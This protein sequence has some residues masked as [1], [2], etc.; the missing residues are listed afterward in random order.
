MKK[1]SKNEF[2]KINEISS[3]FL[4]IFSINFFIDKKPIFIDNIEENQE[5]K[6]VEN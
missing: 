6:K 1:Q 5:F 4:I 3:I 2:K